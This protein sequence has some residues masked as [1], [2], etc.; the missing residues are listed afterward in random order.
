M[1]AWY[2]IALYKSTLYELETIDKSKP[3]AILRLQVF[4]L[5][6]NKTALRTILECTDP[7]YI[8]CA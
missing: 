3:S 7:C 2:P 4:V 6:G 8:N 1:L 5:Y